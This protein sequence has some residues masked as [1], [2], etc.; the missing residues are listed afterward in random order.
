MSTA[1]LTPNDVRMYRY[2][3]I[4]ELGRFPL[5]LSRSLKLHEALEAAI[6]RLDV[7]EMELIVRDA[8]LS[9]EKEKVAAAQGAQ[10]DN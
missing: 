2:E 3:M 4:A 7:V 6:L 9:R 8:E 5:V 10:H 1:R